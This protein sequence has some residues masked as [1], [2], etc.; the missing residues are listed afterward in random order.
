[1]RKRRSPTTSSYDTTTQLTTHRTHHTQ[2][3][4][5]HKQPTFRIANSLS[6]IR[7]QTTNNAKRPHKTATVASTGDW[8]HI[9]DSYKTLLQT[10]AN[11]TRSLCSRA[12]R[13][14]SQNGVLE[15]QAAK[16]SGTHADAVDKLPRRP[17]ASMAPIKKNILHAILLASVY[18]QNREPDAIASA[19]NR[20]TRETRLRL[21]LVAVSLWCWDWCLRRCRGCPAQ[22][23]HQNRT[24]RSRRRDAHMRRGNR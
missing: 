7:R 15:R 9:C 19:R 8:R 6:H 5:N 1:M 12:A 24:S 16:M 17:A 3:L 2:P 14:Q 21:L 18:A 11:T 4:R 23:K 10:C 22:T 20:I 13:T